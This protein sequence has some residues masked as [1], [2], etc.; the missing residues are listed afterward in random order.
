MLIGLP[1]HPVIESLSN[2]YETQNKE[3]VIRNNKFQL[4]IFLFLVFTPLSVFAG[5]YIASLALIPRHVISKTEG[6][7]VELVKAIEKISG[8]QITIQV[9]PFAR[10]MLSVI[11]G[12][13]DFHLPLIKN[14]IIPEK[15]LPYYLSKE[16]IFHVKFV[17]YTLK[18]SKVTLDNLSQYRVETERAHVDYFPF[19]T[20]P[21][22]KIIQSL[23]KL[24]LGRIDA[25]IYADTP[26]DLVLK[27][28][29]FKNIKRR[30]YKRFEVKIVLPK[31]EHG[32]RVDKMLSDAIEKLRKNGKLKEIEGPVDQPYDNWQP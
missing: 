6:I 29:G 21:S 22:N 10:S 18:G 5:Q 16:T 20:I 25:F 26:T 28:L 1:S 15:E 30:F 4:V 13:V 2:T 32:K 19:K 31:N 7:Q 14:D 9:Y 23:Q 8:N 11:K 3:T 12:K 27:D 24:N 17:L